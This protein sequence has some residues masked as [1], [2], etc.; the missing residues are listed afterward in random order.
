MEENISFHAQS[1]RTMKIFALFILL[2]SPL[3]KAQSNP[4]LIPLLDSLVTQDQQWRSLIHKIDNGEIDSLSKK[5]VWENI[6]EIDATNYLEL[7]LLFYEHGF[8]GYDKVGEKGSH[9]FWL[10]TQHMDNHPE[11]Q[12]TVLKEM[13][14][15]VDKGNASPANY[16]YLVDRVKLSKAELQIYG[17][18]L[19]LNMKKNR[20]EARQL[21]DPEKV[22][23]R[24]EDMG[25]PTLESYIEKVNESRLGTK[26]D[27]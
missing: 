16:A 11:F 18:Q 5:F 3:L 22:N 9:N 25:M 17:T 12:D 23:E 4:E 20:Y 14:I 7:V 21:F 1:W 10:L 6:K 27:E 2:I 8:P 26:S 15:E 13:K 19:T 24:R